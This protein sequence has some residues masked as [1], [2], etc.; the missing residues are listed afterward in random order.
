MTKIKCKDTLNRIL[1]DNNEKKFASRELI[2]R[3]DA[4]KIPI[5]HGHY[6][7]IG[8]L[9]QFTYTHIPNIIKPGMKVAD[10]GCGEQP[11]RSLLEYC[12]V[13]YTSIDVIQNKKN[14]VDI[15]A[16][17]SSIP[18]DSNSFDAIVCTEVLEH[19]FDARKALQELSRL[20]KPCGVIIITTPFNFCL[21]EVPYD[22]Q[23]LTPFYLEYW[24]PRL[25]F[26]S[27]KVMQ[28]NGN[29]LEV[30]ATV[31]GE[32]LAPKE[33][34]NI[35]LKAVLAILRTAMNILILTATKLFKRFL[36]CRFFLN[37][38]CIAYKSCQAENTSL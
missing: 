7:V 6:F 33:E 34:T 14:N 22:F 16:D 28:S 27:P 19:C 2:K 31:W 24:L 8:Y 18:L 17:I 20:L 12:D 4:F 15:I 35:V 9:K 11:L 26:D 30:I 23:R 29:E 3:R 38:G 25:G 36:P 13:D 32:M 21:H 5:N 10:I 1:T 37:M